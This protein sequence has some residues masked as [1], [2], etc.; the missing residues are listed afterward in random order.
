MQEF[1][2]NE[3]RTGS[4]IKNVLAKTFL[5]M[6]LGILGTAIVAVFTYT[7]GLAESFVFNGT[8]ALICI[9]ELAV[10]L[11]FSLLFRKLSPTAVTVL[12]FAYAMISG[13]TLSTIFYIYE[14]SSIVIALFGS[15]GVFGALAYAGYKTDKDISSMGN[16]LMIGL[17]VG[18]ILS[19]INIFMASTMLEIVLNWA[20]LA[21]FLGFTLYD[22]NK[23]KMILSSNEYEEDKVAIY[24]AMELYLDF[25]NIFL[26]I[27]AIFGKHRD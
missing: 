1:E 19:I 20:I 14:L 5:W 8:Y 16:I 22:M 6:F 3:V 21:I 18:L 2:Y 9:A 25:I 23:I 13:V 12:F 7:S 27:L 10:V 4:D 26:R 15:A 11:I 17:I 24:G